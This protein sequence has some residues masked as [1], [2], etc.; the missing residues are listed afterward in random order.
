MK[1]ESKFTLKALL[2]SLIVIGALVAAFYLMILH[3]HEDVGLEKI[4]VK[5]GIPLVPVLLGM[6]VL[7]VLILWLLIHF[8]GRSAIRKAAALPAKTGAP[9]RKETAP[10]EKPTKTVPPSPLPAL[11]VL[12]ILQRQGRFIDFIEED[13]SNYSDEQVGAA[14]RDIHRGCKEGLREHM[15]WKPIME[16]EEG[17]QVTVK[18]GFDLESIRLTGNIA[19]E[20]PFKGILRHHGWRVVRVE[21]PRQTREK[22][23]EK[24]WVLSP[25]EVEVG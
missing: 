13:L 21:L 20:P 14:V 7:A 8:S 3:A 4:L 18:P 6:G 19:G 16:E 25:A 23:K 15:E 1:L 10:S 17:A 9:M 12:S 24:E 5:S 2:F 22:E 11:Q